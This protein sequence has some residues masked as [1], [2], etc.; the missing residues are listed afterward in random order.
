MYLKY[1]E[2]KVYAKGENNILLEG[3]LKNV[4]NVKLFGIS[5]M[6][7]L[8]MFIFFVV[9]VLLSSVSVSRRISKMKPIDAINNK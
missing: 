4:F 1:M 8:F 2:Y 3:S 7:L 5:F 9:V 6:P